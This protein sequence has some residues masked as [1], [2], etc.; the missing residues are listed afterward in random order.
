MPL[1]AVIMQ[2]SFDYN[3]RSGTYQAS[4]AGLTIKAV[5]DS[6]SGC[7]WLEW[8]GNTPCIAL[9]DNSFSDYGKDAGFDLLNPFYSPIMTDS[10]LR[11]H[12]GALAKAVGWTSTVLHQEA[13]EYGF[14]NITEAKRDILADALAANFTKSD[15]LEAL[16][17]IYQ[18][19]GFPAACMSSSGYSQG[20]YAE[21]LFVATPQFIKAMGAPSIKDKAYWSKDMEGARKLWSAWAW[22]DVYGFV[23]EKDG[24]HLDSCFGFY[25]QDFEFSG[26]ADAALESAEN[27]I[28]CSK[29]RRQSR[30]AELIKNR[31]PLA[32]RAAILADAGEYENA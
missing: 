30:L 5:Q 13:L 9:S 16:A 29:K 6:D 19:I 4:H 7:P 10:I 31:V 24:E 26:L 3:S 27:I 12:M 14:S 22:G 28:F 21:L 23:I 20:D 18:A 2:L 17:D 11:R 25:G 1:G 15:Q 32:L 8:D